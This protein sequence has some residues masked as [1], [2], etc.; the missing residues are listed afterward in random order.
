MDSERRFFLASPS[1]SSLWSFLRTGSNT[2]REGWLFDVV[3]GT[4]MQD[5]DGTIFGL[6]FSVRATKTVGHHVNLP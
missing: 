5:V 3:I 4:L 6:R 1:S 2:E